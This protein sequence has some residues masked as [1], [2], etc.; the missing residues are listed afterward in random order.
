MEKSCPYCNNLFTPTKK[1]P[2]VVCCSHTCAAK[3]ISAHKPRI[4]FDCEYCGKSESIIANSKSVASR[5]CSRECYDNH[6]TESR[7]MCSHC[8]DRIPSG[9]KKESKNH[10]CSPSCRTSFYQPKHKPCINCGSVFTPIRFDRIYKKWAGH[11][12]GKTCSAKCHNEWI[13]NNPERKRKIG[14][15][16]TGAKHHNWQGG[17]SAINT[18]VH[19]GSGWESTAE[20]A[21][22]RDGRVCKACGKTEIENGRRMDV[23]HIKA[24]HDVNDTKKANRMSNLISLCRVCHRIEENKL[25]CQQ[26]VLPFA[27]IAQTERR[28]TRALLHVQRH[29]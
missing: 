1:H 16:F 6:R 22:D 29:G 24:Y 23:H 12:T 15:A 2:N 19:R 27:L 13:R 10:F 26:I 14:V 8:G 20:K 25:S 5:F 7:P 9:Y 21:R 11:K 17:K 4:V 18:R 28:A 3:M